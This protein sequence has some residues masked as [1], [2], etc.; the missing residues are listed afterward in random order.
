MPS[1]NPLCPQSAEKGLILDSPQ[2]TD[3]GDWDEGGRPEEWIMSLRQRTYG[4][5]GNDSG[6]KNT[7]RHGIDVNPHHHLASS[8]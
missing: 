1:P 5:R 8:V 7:T 4:G 3:M 2:I 6:S